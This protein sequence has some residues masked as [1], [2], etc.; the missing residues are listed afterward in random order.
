[1]TKREIANLCCRVLAVYVLV[2]GVSEAPSVLVMIASFVSREP[3]TM[4]VWLSIAYAV[5]PAMLIIGG[6]VLWRRS[7]IVAALMTGHDLQDEPDEPDV[8]RRRVTAAEAHGIAFSTM[9][10]W[11]LVNSVPNL[12]TTAVGMAAFS[13]SDRPSELEGLGRSWGLDT[14]GTIAETIIG[15]YLLFGASGLVRLLRRAR[16]FGL[17]ERERPDYPERQDAGEEH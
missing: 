8:I 17:E 15:V 9:G 2:Q 12:V 13:Q 1:M 6:I 3:M 11:L 4:F 10:L 7:S 5:H 14:L 16:D